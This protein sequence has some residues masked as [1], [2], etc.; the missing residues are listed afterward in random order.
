MDRIRHYISVVLNQK[1]PFRFIYSILLWRTRLCQLFTIDR[2]LYRIQFFPTALSA[3]YWVNPDDREADEDFFISYLKGGDIVLDIGA[4]IG[5]LTLTAASI[6]GDSGKV[7]SIEAHPVIYRYLQKNVALNGF[8]NICLFNVA[9]GNTK[10]IVSFS[11]KLSDDQNEIIMTNGL[12]IHVEKLDDLLFDKL[13]EVSYI[14]LLKVDVEGYEKFVFQGAHK[15]LQKTSCVYF[16][17]WERLYAKYGYTSS[18]VLNMLRSCGFDIY[19][20]KGDKIILIS[21][22]YDAD[23]SENLLAIRDLSDF[24]KRTEKREAFEDNGRT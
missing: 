5:T 4:N 2:G 22:T 21:S 7:F 16:E 11:N 3:T 10:G 18:E 20:I 12:Q 19:R 17:N 8:R 6:V 1:Q 24:M 14:A 13:E 15:I 23:I 9:I